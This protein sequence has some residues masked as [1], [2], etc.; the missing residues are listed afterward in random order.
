MAQTW[1]GLFGLVLRDSGVAAQGQTPS[2]QMMNDAKTRCQMM[3]SQWVRR[4]WLV[5]HLVET[6]CA[7]DGSLFYNVGPGEVLNIMRADQIQAAFARQTNAAAP[8]NQVDYPMRAITSFEDYS[9][10]PMKQLSA[11]PAYAFFFDS[12]YPVG[13]FYPYPLMASGYSIH[14]LTKAEFDQ[15]AVITDDIMFPPEYLEAIYANS[16]RRTRMAFQL[17]P[18]P[19]VNR[20]ATAALETLRATNWQPAHLQMPA[21]LA[22][23]GGSGYNIFSDQFSGG[24]R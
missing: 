3:L 7:C 18:D 10:I 4:R 8:P 5:Y 9:R 20:M 11:G 19:E 14:I 23:I 2:A 1:A 22:P 21:A 16:I 12:S 24:N 13:R 15:I 17:P 6:S